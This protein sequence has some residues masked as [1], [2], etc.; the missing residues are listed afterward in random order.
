MKLSRVI[1]NGVLVFLGIGIYF[2]LMELLGLSNQPFLR[3]LNIV[4]VVFGVNR[5]IRQNAKEGVRGYNTNFLSAILTSMIGAILSIAVLLI[6]INYS[7]GEVHLE[8]LSHGFM[9]GG[10]K[11]SIPQY[12]FGLLLE[13]AAASLIVSFTLMQYWKDKIE[14]INK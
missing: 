1:T 7:G 10:G 2:L 14:V 3:I 6:Y 5:T 9:F 4:F 12:C 13:S 11:P 8:K